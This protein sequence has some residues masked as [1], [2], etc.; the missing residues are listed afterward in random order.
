MV[1]ED[2]MNEN[3]LRDLKRDDHDDTSGGP[4][5]DVMTPDAELARARHFLSGWTL[6]R[7][8]ARFRAEGG[9]P[10]LTTDAEGGEGGDGGDGVTPPPPMVGGGGGGWTR[11]GPPPSTTSPPSSRRMRRRPSGIL[12]IPT[13]ATVGQVSVSESGRKSR[14]V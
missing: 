10:S 2:V 6:A 7:Y 9:D 1:G 5:R 12:T 14:C 13:C 8:T 11:V 4:M 3:K